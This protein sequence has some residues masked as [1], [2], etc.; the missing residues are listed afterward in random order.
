MTRASHRHRLGA[1]AAAHRPC[2]RRPRGG[3]VDAA[4]AARS[5]AERRPAAAAA[6]GRPPFSQVKCSSND[7]PLSRVKETY[8]DGRPH[9]WRERGG[10][11]MGKKHQTLR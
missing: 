10:G 2:H 3:D 1:A 4:G 5:V 9:P 11:G 8:P 6:Q 7:A